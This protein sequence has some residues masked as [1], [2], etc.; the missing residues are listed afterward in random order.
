MICSNFFYLQK[1]GKDMEETIK[2]LEEEIKKKEEELKELKK[3]Y[4]ILNII[5]MKEKRGK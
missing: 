2:K 5:Y 1:E 3:K 4:E